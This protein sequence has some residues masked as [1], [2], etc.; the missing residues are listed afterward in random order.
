M[1][2]LLEQLEL[3]GQPPAAVAAPLRHL[4]LGHVLD[5]H[6][7]VVRPPH[8]GIHL[9]IRAVNKVVQSIRGVVLSWG[10]PLLG[11]SPG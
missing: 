2:Y 4:L 3:E 10:R 1:C 7:Q 9:R 8:P 5:G 6:G 11:P